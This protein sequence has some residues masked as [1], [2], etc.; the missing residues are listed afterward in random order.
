MTTPTSTWHSQVLRAFLSPI[1]RFCLR[2]ALPVQGVIELVKEALVSE[3]KRQLE[4]AGTKVNVSR[5]SVATGLH[6]RDVLRLTSSGPQEERYATLVSRV[7][8]QW[9]S[10]ARFCTQQNSPRVLRLD[11]EPGEFKELVSSV[12]RDVNPAAVLAEMERLEVAKRTPR[13]IQLSK[14]GAVEARSPADGFL[15]AAEDVGTLYS[16]I[17][18]NVTTK[19]ELPNLH[20]R[21]EFD[22]IALS[23]VPEVQKWLLE[24]GADLHRRARVF[25][26]KFDLDLEPTLPGPG[27]VKVT[28]GSFGF[29][30]VP[31]EITEPK[32]EN[33]EA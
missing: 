3:A 24:Q 21:T 11:D 25:L 13:G 30:A 10:Q 6:R 23:A 2:F 32:D 18:Q 29:V 12:S 16:A 33:I 17:E 9:E 1:A 8:H 14:S 20:I 15:L 22:N 27:G 26:A 31:E 28:L 19:S 5:L 4:R 7:V